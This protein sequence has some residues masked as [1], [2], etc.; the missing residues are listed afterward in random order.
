MIK[1]IEHTISFHKRLK[2]LRNTL[3]LMKGTD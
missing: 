1:K 3:V 2:N